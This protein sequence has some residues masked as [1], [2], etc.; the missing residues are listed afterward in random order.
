MSP[1]L[2]AIG[3]VSGVAGAVGAA[4][5]IVL[6]PGATD[7]DVISGLSAFALV[8]WAVSWIEAADDDWI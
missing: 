7:M 2:R 5:V 3:L 1:A 8:W 4:G 6:A